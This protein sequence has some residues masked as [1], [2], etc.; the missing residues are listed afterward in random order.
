MQPAAV[1]G[2]VGLAAFVHYNDERRAV[3][4]GTIFGLFYWF[5]AAIV[6][7]FSCLLSTLKYKKDHMALAVVLGLGMTSRNRR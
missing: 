6:I 3:L 7:S 5:L 2:F 1:M 4:K